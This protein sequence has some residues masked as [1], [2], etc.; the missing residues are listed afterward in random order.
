MSAKL[1]K[2]LFSLHRDGDDLSVFHGT[3][4]VCRIS[5][6]FKTLLEVVFQPGGEPLFGGRGSVGIGLFWKRPNCGDHVPDNFNVEGRIVGGKPRLDI[7]C[8]DSKGVLSHSMRMDISWS[9]SLGSYVFDVD[10]RVKVGKGKSWKTFEAGWYDGMEYLNPLPS[11]AFN[12]GWDH[13]EP[14]PN[15]NPPQMQPWCAPERYQHC[16]YQAHDGKW[17]SFPLNH[18]V[19]SWANR[20]DMG[21]DGLFA[22]VAESAGNPVVQLMGD[23][24]RKSNVSL[25]HALYDTHF[26]LPHT[27]WAEGGT[28]ARAQYRLFAV[29]KKQALEWLRQ[30]RKPVISGWERW[31]MGLPVY[32]PPGE[33]SD[34]DRVIRPDSYDKETLWAPTDARGWWGHEIP[35]DISDAKFAWN[36][37]D[38]RDGGGAVMVW[39]DNDG[40]WGWVSD[41]HQ[42]QVAHNTKYRLTAWVKTREVVGSGSTIG[43]TGNF[44]IGGKIHKDHNSILL[45]PK[46]IKGSSK[47]TKLQFD[48]PKFGDNSGTSKDGYFYR[49][50]VV[51]IWLLQEGKG[52]T[53]FDDVLLEEIG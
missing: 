30:S 9:E 36:P 4:K 43:I 44:P 8:S 10:T 52:T 14:W 21:G 5:A 6:K 13:P 2:N 15:H 18:L 31:R 35:V 11:G 17:N 40:P 48:L 22:Y 29:G 38:G 47:W 23:T 1:A 26:V 53:W 3:C 20:L 46:R 34:F 33:L 49:H 37:H 45:C 39:S 25:C 41:A 27:G 19:S 32:A 28:E 51:K 42:K 16:V 12:Q 24:R 7:S 50:N